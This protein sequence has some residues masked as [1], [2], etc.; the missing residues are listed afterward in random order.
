MQDSMGQ[1]GERNGGRP[2]SGGT[3]GATSRNGA[4]S[5][6]KAHHG[7]VQRE[8]YAGGAP[9]LLAP[10]RTAIVARMKPG[11]G[12]YVDVEGVRTYYVR[13]GPG[14]A[15]LLLH[16]QPPGASLHVVWEPNLDYFAEA[17]FT[18]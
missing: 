18:V 1:S 11:T 13:K 15:L 6:E 8:R 5:P 12:A 17:G 16:G 7:Q 14:P 4:S 9:S 3:R 10:R 2:G